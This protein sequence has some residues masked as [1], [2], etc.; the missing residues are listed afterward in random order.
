MSETPWSWKSGKKSKYSKSQRKV[1]E[2]IERD[3]SK[4]ME[5]VKPSRYA[6]SLSVARTA[7]QMALAY[8]EDPYLAL[9]AG[10]LHDWDK[11]LSRNEQIEKAKECGIDLG[12][13]YD[14][15]FPLLHGMTA[16]RTL[17][18]LYPK[19]PMAVWQAVSRHTLGAVDMTPLDMIVF[20]ADGIE[21]RRR[22]VPAIAHVREMVEKG[23]PLPDVYWSSFSQGVAYVVQTERYL[24]PGTLEIYNELV[25]ARKRS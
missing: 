25:L 7:E 13:P 20:V 22:G 24:Y 14:L 21:P 2:G 23:A 17:P 3:L 8:G 5:S 15:V 16:T 4:R 10:V 19:F 12:V 11:V 1:L 18:E 6:H 9:V